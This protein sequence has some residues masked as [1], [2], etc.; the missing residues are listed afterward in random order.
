MH[1]QRMQDG[2]LWVKQTKQN[3]TPFEAALEQSIHRLPLRNCREPW[4][5]TRGVQIMTMTANLQVLRLQAPVW[6]AGPGYF[7]TG[8]G[9]PV[10]MLHSS[11]SSKSQWTALGER[12]AP[13][14]RAI[15]L[16][17]CGYG[18]NALVTA[19]APFTLDQEVQLVADR[20]KPLMK[21]HVR[22]HLV[23]HSYGAL[24]AL[25]LAQCWRDRVSSLS[26]YEPVAFGLLDQADAALTHLKWTVERL[27]R[28][29]AAGR[30]HDAAQVFVNFWSGDGSYARLSPST[31]A[32]IVRRVDK[33]PL[34]FQ[35]AW[36]WPPSREDL[37]RIGAPTLLLAGRRSPAVAQRIHALLAQTLSN[38]RVG[39]LDSGHMGPIT[40][41]RRVN[42][43]IAAFLNMC[44][45]VELARAAP[46][47]IVSPL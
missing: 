14:F 31:Q 43:W 30:R 39:S 38:R 32:S 3:P 12:L 37:R 1:P 16:D 19:D 11:L 36:S 17:L 7:A 21:A 40:D 4:R 20:L 23:G 26:L 13:R 29:L 42:R 46:Q 47:A 22:F 18:D 34:D 25:R 24:V 28:L 35:A 41:A 27:S 33:L 15:A 2:R 45:G 44:E 8:A 6:A 9:T 10:V 5:F